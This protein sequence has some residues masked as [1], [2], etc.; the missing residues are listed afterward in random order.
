MDR[1]RGMNWDYSTAWWVA[2]GLLIVLELTSGTFYLLM[3]AIGTVMGALTAHAG[4]PCA[5][6]G[7]GGLGRRGRG[8][9]A[10]PPARSPHHPARCREPGSEPRRGLARAGR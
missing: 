4:L 8:A 1:R 9:L 5:I 6:G 7:R 2:T 3:L 10:S